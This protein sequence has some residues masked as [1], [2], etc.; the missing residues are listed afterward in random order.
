MA[1]HIACRFHVLNGASLIHF[2]FLNFYVHT[3][4]FYLLFIICTNKCTHIQV[5]SRIRGFSIRGFN[6]PP[7]ASARKKWKIKEI[8]GS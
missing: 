2:D 1:L 3:V 6:Y 7:L 8:N 5:V 4:H